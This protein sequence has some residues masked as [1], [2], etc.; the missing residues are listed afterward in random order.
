MFFFKVTSFYFTIN[1]LLYNRYNIYNIYNFKTKT[2]A[3]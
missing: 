1:K 2:K 3:A